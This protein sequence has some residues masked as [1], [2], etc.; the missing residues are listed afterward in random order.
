METPNIQYVLS[1][2]KRP[3]D[4]GIGQIFQLAGHVSGRRCLMTTKLK[5]NLIVGVLLLLLVG[6]IMLLSPVLFGALILV[7]IFVYV[8]LK[9]SKM[10]VGNG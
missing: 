4:Y 1:A 9:I 5:R 8:G 2:I 6:T 7:G 10:E 3:V